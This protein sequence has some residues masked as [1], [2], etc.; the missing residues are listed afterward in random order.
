[1]SHTVRTKVA[2]ND[3]GALARCI[4]NMGGGVLGQGTHHL[5]AGDETG[6]GFTLPG[7]RYPLV[8]S[9]NG[10]LKYD[11]YHGRWGNVDD[12]AKLKAGYAIAVA[13]QAAEQQGYESEMIGE[14]LVI[15]FQNGE[16]AT[17]TPDGVV[18]VNGVVGSS[19]EGLTAFLENALGTVES[20]ECKADFFQESA[21]IHLTE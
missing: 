4:Q 3:P 9:A 6:F 2:Y 19:C 15:K 17:V 16:Y 5:F 20:R 1:M 11:D 7:W 13:K 10:E 21:K 12:L 14:N 18:D 8:L